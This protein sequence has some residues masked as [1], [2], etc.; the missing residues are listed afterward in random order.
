MIFASGAG[1]STE[2]EEKFFPLELFV[3]QHSGPDVEI[4]TYEDAEDAVRSI[5]ADPPDLL[6]LDYRLPG[7]NGDKVAQ[8][9][10]LNIPIALVTGDLT[11][12]PTMQFAKIFAKPHEPEE[13]Q[14]F[15]ESVIEAKRRFGTI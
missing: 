8:R 1:V 5:S 13:M 14:S 2:I 6:I 10:N 9:L 3:D 11:V 4:Q 7:T 15:I 12:S